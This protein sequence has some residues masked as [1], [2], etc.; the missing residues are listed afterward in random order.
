MTR[1]SLTIFFC[2]S[3]LLHAIPP[4]ILAWD[5]EVAARKL[6]I[7][8]STDV[9]EIEN[10]H[11]SKRTKSMKL[12]GAAP[13]FI[14]ALDKNAAADGKPVQVELAIPPTMKSPLIL[15][16]PD[17]THPTGIRPMVIEDSTEGF[18]WGTFRFLNVTPK[19]LVVQIEEKAVRVPSGWQPVDVN[20]GG[21]TRGIGARIALA[22]A[23]QKPLYSAVW[24]YDKN[25][26]TLCILVP[27]TDARTSPVGL[28][29][30][31]EDK[32]SL[33]LEAAD[34]AKKNPQPE[35]KAEP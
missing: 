23:I 25:A 17:T 15:L 32:I 1:F 21:E 13:F 8:S 7:A 31:P 12:K 14:R 18:N 19:E 20:L 22:E 28:K 4:R 9:I 5:D 24:E 35:P 16:M 6:A 30:I 27:G 34:N 33:E 10:M 3:S 11:P 26:R 2:L 29:A